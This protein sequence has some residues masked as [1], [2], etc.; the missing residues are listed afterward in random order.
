MNKISIKQA[1]KMSGLSE[2]YIRKAIKKGDIQTTKELIGS[3]KVEKNWLDAD[4]FNSW[5]EAAS[6]H[7][8]R[9]DGR[10][11]FVVYMN[12]DEVAELEQ[13][14]NTMP[15]LATLVRANKK[16]E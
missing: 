3:T 6:Q 12:A 10:N 14:T 16:A 8:K 13:L 4:Q 5:R 15:F 2:N 7:S 11:K 1:V 9:E